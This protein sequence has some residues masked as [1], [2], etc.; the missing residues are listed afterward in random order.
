MTTVVTTKDGWPA[1]PVS[2]RD[3]FAAQAIA[4]LADTPRADDE[5]ELVAD[6]A[7]RL[8]DAMLKAR[9]AK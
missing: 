5:M 9:E 2:L 6:R 3:Y 8:A 4:A 7:Y 1:L